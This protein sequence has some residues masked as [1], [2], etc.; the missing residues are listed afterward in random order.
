MKFR[1]IAA[2]FSAGIE[3]VLSKIENHEAVAE[4]AIDDLRKAGAQIK[5]QRSRARKELERLSE[6]LDAARQAEQDWQDR[7]LRFA[8]EDEAKALACLKRGEGQQQ[9]IAELDQQ[10]QAH[11]ELVLELESTLAQAESQLQSLALKKSALTARGARSRS[12][13]KVEAASNCGTVQDIFDRW[14]TQVLADEAVDNV[15]SEPTD[16]LEQSLLAEEEQ[17][18]LRAKLNALRNKPA[19][20]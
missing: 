19:P 17:A 7:A 15:S 11:Q 1:R 2:T 5:V 16:P 12:M 3:E 6:Q 4:C 18:R 9:R 14:E 8:A 10:V 13:R 20:S